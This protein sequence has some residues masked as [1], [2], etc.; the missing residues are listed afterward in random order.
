[1]HRRNGTGIGGAIIKRK[2]SIYLANKCSCL[3]NVFSD[4]DWANILQVSC[5]SSD[6]GR[7]D[8]KVGKIRRSRVHD[9]TNTKHCRH[10]RK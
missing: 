9:K 7:L 4:S 10:H 5:T 2:S 6:V 8:G 1:M 3:Q